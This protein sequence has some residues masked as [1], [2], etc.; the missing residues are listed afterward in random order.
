M[1]GND[2]IRSLM[3]LGRRRGVPV[4]VD[5]KRGKGSHLVLYFGA[6]KSVVPDPQRELKTGTLHGILK[7]LGLT[8]G[9]LG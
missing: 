1:R 5:A 9:D 3:K 8:P 4:R 2:L 6:R 7:Q